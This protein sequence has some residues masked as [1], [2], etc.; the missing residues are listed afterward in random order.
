MID[1]RPIARLGEIEGDG[2]IAGPPDVIVRNSRGEIAL[3]SEDNATHIKVYS[4]A[5]KF[6]RDVG[7][8]GKGPGEFQSITAITLVADSLY[9]FDEGN[10][11]VTI[12]SP[13]YTFIRAFPIQIHVDDAKLLPSGEFVVNGDIHSRDRVGF[14]L[15]RL[16]RSGDIVSSFGSQVTLNRRFSP[17]LLRR[18]LALSSGGDLWVAHTTQYLLEHVNSGGAIDRRLIRQANWFKPYVTPWDVTPK[19]PPPSVMTDLHADSQNR[20]WASAIFPVRRYSKYL[21]KTPTLME[22]QRVYRILDHGGMYDSYLEVID[23]VKG[24]VLARRQFDD[25]IAGWVDANHF[26]TY[27]EKDGVPYV[28]VWRASLKSR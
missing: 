3:A 21:S 13:D 5:G 10:Y 20:L 25:L 6:L 14:P 18:R 7:K 15:H 27:V 24:Q 23:P 28:T 2:T 11:R 22:G 26:A 19:I 12:L 1:A 17:G 8:K 9:I 4:P 16:N